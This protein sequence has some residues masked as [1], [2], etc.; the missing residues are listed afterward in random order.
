MVL[1]LGDDGRTHLEPRLGLYILIPR[2]FPT[3]IVTDEPHMC[4]QVNY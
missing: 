4:C 1:L 3:N 2:A